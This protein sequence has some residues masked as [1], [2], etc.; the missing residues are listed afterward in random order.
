MSNKRAVWI[1]Y[2]GLAIELLILLVSW[3]QTET[4]A[5]F[6]Q[7]C[8]RYSGRLSLLIF[9]VAFLSYPFNRIG[10]EKRNIQKKLVSYFAIIHII[11]FGFL[12]TYIYL[13]G[14][15]LIPIRLAGG[16]FA[17]LLI[18]VYPVILTLNPTAK[19]WNDYF[20]KLYYYYVW[21]IFFL[22]YL[23]RIR[24][25]LPDVSGNL[26]TYYFLFV[27]VILLLAVQLV[28]MRKNFQKTLKQG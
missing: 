21:L 23:P 10:G 14:N 7:S 8:S 24:Q 28:L 27:Y 2:F 15:E 6:F 19:L 5:T 25:Q 20:P 18:V 22:S 9:S 11:H 26:E 16:A 3:Y 12:S 17:Y 4:V 1:L 13:S